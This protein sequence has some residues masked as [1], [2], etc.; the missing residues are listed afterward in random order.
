MDL[1]IVVVL[2]V[3]LPRTVP[4]YPAFISTL[5]VVDIHPPT[6]SAHPWGDADTPY[7]EIGGDEAVKR[8]AERFYDIVEGTSPALADMLPA[9]T[10]VSRQKL[11]EFLSGWTGGPALYWE[12]RGHPALRMRHSPFP[13]DTHAAEEWKRCMIEAIREE[14]GSA[15]AGAFLERELAR[16]ATQLRNQID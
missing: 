6:D 13:I 5:P 9:D 12:R 15:P 2:D 14:V 16:A 8:L 7:E 11:Y 1:W 10:S 3:P 4:E